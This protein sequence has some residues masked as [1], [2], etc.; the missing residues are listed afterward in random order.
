MDIDHLV[1]LLQ[2]TLQ[3]DQRVDAEKQLIE[4]CSTW[5]LQLPDTVSV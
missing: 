1:A 2:G 4:V 3:P 5:W